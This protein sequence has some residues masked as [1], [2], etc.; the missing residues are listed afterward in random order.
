LPRRFEAMPVSAPDGQPAHY[1]IT[2]VK[3]NPGMGAMTFMNAAD[4][5]DKTLPGGPRHSRGIHEDITFVTLGQYDMVMVWRAPDL[6][7]MG[8]YWQELIDACGP[9]LGK[10]ET[11]VALSKGA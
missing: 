3:F 2:M 4:R 1:F 5:V 11:L 8:K 6:A 9:E 10:T 7:T